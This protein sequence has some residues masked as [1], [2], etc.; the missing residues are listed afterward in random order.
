M[1]III[2]SICIIFVASIVLSCWY[3]YKH[4]CIQEK[5]YCYYEIYGQSIGVGPVVGGKS[6]GAAV[7]VSPTISKIYVDCNN[8]DNTPKKIQYENKC[9]LRK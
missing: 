5:T 9:I 6:G 4:P 8:T 7:T 3:D 1:K 2:I